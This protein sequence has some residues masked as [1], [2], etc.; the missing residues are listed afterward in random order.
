MFF[1]LGTAQLLNGAALRMLFKATSSAVAL[2]DDVT[3]LTSATVPSA[4]SLNRQV[5]A[6]AKT[7]E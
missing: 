7:V 2:P 6:L 5:V 4:K 3:N 1:S